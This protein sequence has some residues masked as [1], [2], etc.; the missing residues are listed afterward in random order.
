[1][2]D[3]WKY[4]SKCRRQP[5]YCTLYRRDAH[6]QK[7]RIGFQLGCQQKWDIEHICTL[8]K[9]LA[10]ALFLGVR[11]GHVRSDSQDSGIKHPQ[12]LPKHHTT[13]SWSLKPEPFK[14]VL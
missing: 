11:V 10:D 14:I 8:G 12:Q 2:G 5:M 6:L 3:D 13:N 7:M 1:M 9:A 4:R